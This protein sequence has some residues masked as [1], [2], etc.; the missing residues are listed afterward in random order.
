MAGA[1]G[2]RADVS[3]R[4]AAWRCVLR[5]PAQHRLQHRPRRLGLRVVDDGHH[6]P[7][8][9]RRRIDD[10][11]QRDDIAQ[12]AGLKVGPA[13]RRAKAGRLTAERAVQPGQRQRTEQ[14]GHP[15]LAP[16]PAQQFGE[17]GRAQLRLA[18]QARAV[19]DA[20]RR[21]GAGA[22]FQPGLQPHGRG[23][24]R[25]RRDAGRARGAEQHL[26][27]DQVVAGLV[28]VAQ[29]LGQRRAT[30]LAAELHVGTLC[31]EPI[32]HGPDMGGL[33]GTVDAL[34][35]DESSRHLPRM[36][37]LTARL[38]AARSSLNSLLPSPRATK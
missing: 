27:G 20:W 5:D 35:A 33:A 24:G 18:R 2:G 13:G 7:A 15:G 22:G 8:P 26:L 4:R 23:L 19:D 34:E 32:G 30:G 17:L 9:A 37:L 12:R 6:H 21:R 3:G 1:N 11:G 28:H 25:R 29:R 10:A 31:T 16:G 14:L 38:C 36:Y